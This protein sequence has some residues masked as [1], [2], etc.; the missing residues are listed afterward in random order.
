MRAAPLRDL[1]II[2]F[3]FKP[4]LG[5]GGLGGLGTERQGGGAALSLRKKV[6]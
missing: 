4:P 2:G 1:E 5:K 6:I 3:C